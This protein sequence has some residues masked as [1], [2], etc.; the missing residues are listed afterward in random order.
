MC[1][2]TFSRPAFVD[3][4][5][6]GVRAVAKAIMTQWT[7]AWELDSLPHLKVRHAKSIC[8]PNRSIIG[9][10]TPVTCSP[11]VI[12]FVDTKA[13]LTGVWHMYSAALKYQP[14]T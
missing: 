5:C 12:L 10:Q 11:W 4:L 7:A 8:V 3:D 6:C 14:A 1:A 2:A 13:A 9:C